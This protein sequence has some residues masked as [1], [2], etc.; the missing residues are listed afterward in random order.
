MLSR[1]D[2]RFGTVSIYRTA[3]F[4]HLGRTYQRS[5]RFL[6][7][8]YQSTLGHLMCVNYEDLMP[9][10]RDV[11]HLALQHSVSVSKDDRLDSIPETKFGQYAGHVGLYR[12][13]RQVKARSYFM[14]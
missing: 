12:R 1:D 5:E 14:V 4:A 10:S 11:F 8:P 6:R 3:V 13:L 7:D 9:Y 2:T